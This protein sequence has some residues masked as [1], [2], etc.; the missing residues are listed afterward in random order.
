MRDKLIT[1]ARTGG[2]RL[3]KLGDK[4]INPS[5][6][7]Q[8]K[9]ME[10]LDLVKSWKGQY[11]LVEMVEGSDDEFK[12]I[13]LASVCKQSDNYVN[14][15]PV[16]TLEDY[17]NKTSVDKGIDKID[18][19]HIISISGQKFIKFSGLLDIAYKEGLQSI[20]N[21]LIS[22]DKEKKMFIFRSRVSLKDGRVFEG[23]GDASPENVNKMIVP[24]VLRMAETRA[25]ARALRWAT[26]IGMCSFEELGEEIGEK[27]GN[28][29]SNDD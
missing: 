7:Y 23:Y 29:T 21:E 4:W 27:S 17:N 14:D 6:D 25:I 19:S 12:G 13:G 24:H 16:Q 22:E 9:L 3:Q 1:V 5:K 8:K 2:I 10:N 26:N 28:K 20:E 11:V 15:N 18:S